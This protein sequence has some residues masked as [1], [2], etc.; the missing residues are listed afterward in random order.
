M[1][2]TVNSPA[3]TQ[4]DVDDRKTVGLNRWIVYRGIPC[5]C[6]EAHVAEVLR[7]RPPLFVRTVFYNVLIDVKLSSP[8]RRSVCMERN[9]PG[10]SITLLGTVL[11]TLVNS[12][13][14]LKGS[15]IHRSLR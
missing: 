3:S 12:C 6:S 2:E 13:V 1:P 15:D 7:R 14:T 9:P 5:G 11:R 4:H 10:F 8:F